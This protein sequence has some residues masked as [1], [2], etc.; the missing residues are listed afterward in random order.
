MHYQSFEI[1]NFKGIEYAEL[2]LSTTKNARVITLVGLNESGKTTVLEAIHSFAPDMSADTVVGNTSRGGTNSTGAVPR[3]KISYF[4]GE[5]SIAAVVGLD[6]GDLDAIGEG[7][8]EHDLHIDLG[9]VPQNFKFE[10]V[11]SYQNG[12][13][14]NNFFRIGF[15]PLVKK[16]RQ[17]KFRSA[18]KDELNAVA[19]TLR[20]LMPTIAYFPTFVFDFPERIYLSGRPLDRRNLFYRLLFQDILDFGGKGFQIQ[21]HITGRIQ[22]DGF[23]LEWAGFIPFFRKSTEWEQIDQVVRHAARTVS[24]VVYSKWNEIFHEDPGKKEIEISWDADEGLQTKDQQ[25]KGISPTE[26]DIFIQ[27][28]VKDGADTYPIET[29]SLGFRWFFSFL[30]FTQFRAGRNNGRPVIFLLD[31]PASNLHAS[32]QQKLI[33]SFPEIARPPH[34]LIYST[35]SHYLVHPHWLEQTY[36]VQNEPAHASGNLID[37]AMLDDATV[38]VEVTPYKQFIS[39]SPSKTIYFQ[40]IIDRL[41]V[42]PSRFDID[43]AGILVEGKSDYYILQYFNRRYLSGKLR[44]YPCLGAGTMSA[45]IALLRGWGKG[46]RVVLDSDEAG[47]K[48]KQRYAREFLL[49]DNEISLISDF[50]PNLEEVEDLFTADDLNKM[51]LNAT[52]GNATKKGILL[53]FQEGLSSDADILLSKNTIDRAKT[54]LAQLEAFSK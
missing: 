51:G 44:L 30:L 33:E 29:R 39:K 27:F 13:P 6:D 34:H 25:E 22:Q 12:S 53:A 37:E 5:V 46:I 50:D 18:T 7:L 35:H 23:K 45:L 24:K 21:D 15:Q 31:E 17:K 38:K 43:A 9:A 28:R 2:E 47:K 8:L 41:S 19:N 16:P 14:V 3:S 40:P 26:H 20:Y 1:R 49:S 11:S 36:I 48:E 52:K 32:A 54:L 42:V 10:R 4:T